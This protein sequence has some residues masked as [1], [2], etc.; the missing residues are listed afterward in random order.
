MIEFPRRQ[1]FC[2]TSFFFAALYPKDV[3]YQRTGRLLEE[4]LAQKSPWTTWDMFVEQR[5]S[6]YTALIRAPP[7]VSWMIEPSLRVVYYDRSVREEAD[8]FSDCL[9]RSRA[10]FV[11]PSL[12]SSLVVLQE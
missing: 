3:N 5:P 2:D 8:G 1:A 7:F 12:M 11:T 10:L 4:A 9:Q 6:F